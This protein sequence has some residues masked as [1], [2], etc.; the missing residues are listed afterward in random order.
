MSSLTM[1]QIMRQDIAR[2]G[3]LPWDTFN[4]E[5]LDSV[6]MDRMCRAAEK[7]AAEKRAEEARIRAIASFS[8]ARLLYEWLQGGR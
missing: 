7:R 2:H 4:Q 1:V 3:P 6:R 8:R 5:A